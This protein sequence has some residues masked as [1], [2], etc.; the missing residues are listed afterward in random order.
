M[1][2]Q[3]IQNTSKEGESGFNFDK[4]INDSGLLD[5]KELFIKH[6]ATTCK[7]LTFVSVEIQTMMTDPEL[8]AQPLMIPKIMSALH[9]ISSYVVTIVISEA[10]Q[11]VIDLLKQNLKLL[12]KINTDL[13][14]LKIE[15]PK[16]KQKLYNQKM[17]Q[18]K[19]VKTKI[20][21]TFDHLFDALN[22]RKQFLL[23]QV[24]NIK[25]T[26]NTYDEKKKNDDEKEFETDIINICENKIK[27]LKIF[28]K[29]NEEKY[30]K[31]ISTNKDKTDRKKKK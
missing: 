10:E 4:W 26:Q 24:N 22:K 13:Q 15:Y 5:I 17:K 23:Q 21:S 6:N 27:N 28:L 29:E 3:V 9:N 16:S 8:L 1:S 7:T 30:D 20:N 31:I 18:I 12:D 19:T 2:S 25:L 14:T 11:A